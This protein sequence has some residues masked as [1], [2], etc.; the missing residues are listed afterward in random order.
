MLSSFDAEMNQKALRARAK[1]QLRRLRDEANRLTARLVILEAMDGKPRLEVLNA[2]LFDQCRDAAA[3][4]PVVVVREGPVHV[5]GTLGKLKRRRL[6]LTNATA[7]FA[8]DVASNNTN[9]TNSNNNNSNESSAVASAAHSLLSFVHYDRPGARH[10]ASRLEFV[11]GDKVIAVQFASEDESDEWLRVILEQRL[12]LLSLLLDMLPAFRSFILAGVPAKNAAAASSASAPRKSSTQAQVT[13]DL[14]REWEQI[15]E[16][17]PAELRASVPLQ[18]Q[19][20]AIDDPLLLKLGFLEYQRVMML[21]SFASKRIETFATTVETRIKRLEEL[22]DKREALRGEILKLESDL[23]QQKKQVQGVGRDLSSIFDDVLKSVRVVHGALSVQHE[24]L[25]RRAATVFSGIALENEER[26][27][28]EV[29]RDVLEVLNGGLTMDGPLK[30][31]LEELD[32]KETQSAAEVSELEQRR[33]TLQAEVEEEAAKRGELRDVLQSAKSLQESLRSA[34]SLIEKSPKPV[35]LVKWEQIMDTCESGSGSAP[36]DFRKASGRVALRVLQRQDEAVALA[37]RGGEKQ[38][39][40]SSSSSPAADGSDED[41]L[42]P[43]ALVDK[44]LHASHGPL[45]MVV[46]RTFEYYMQ[47]IKLLEQL[48]LTYC[49]TPPTTNRVDAEDAEK[50]LA[51]IRL[52]VLN[53]LRKWVRMHRYHFQSAVMAQMLKNFLSC[54]RL[55]GNEKIVMQIEAEMAAADGESVSSA[56]KFVSVPMLRSG[57]KVATSLEDVKP[58]ELA[59]QL[60]LFDQAVYRKLE[61]REFIKCVFMKKDSQELAPTVKKFTAQF[62]RVAA[63]CATQV[64]SQGAPEARLQTMCFWLETCAHLRRL[65]NYSSLFAIVGGLQSS[66]VKRL[67]GTWAGVPAALISIFESATAL[68]DKNFSGLRAELESAAPPV[69]PY[70]GTYQ[71]DLVYL[72]EGATWKG[73]FVNISKFM[74]ISSVLHNIF[75]YQVASY[76][77]FEELPAIQKILADV[78]VLNED[79]QH[80]RSLAVEPR[81]RGS[82][83]TVVAAP[84]AGRRDTGKISRNDS[85]ASDRPP[86]AQVAPV[87]RIVGDADPNSKNASSSLVASFAAQNALIAPRSADKAASPKPS[88]R[89]SPK[90]SPRDAPPLP[91]INLGESAPEVTSTRTSGALPNAK[92][93]A[94]EP[95]S[96]IAPIPIAVAPAVVTIT[97]TEAAPLSRGSGSSAD[98]SSQLS[99]PA[100]KQWGSASPHTSPRSS[101]TLGVPPPDS[102]KTRVRRRKR[103]IST[104]RRKGTAA[105]PDA[106]PPVVDAAGGEVSAITVVDEE[107]DEEEEDEN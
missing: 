7:D 13:E 96:T 47:P 91:V 15:S 58:E 78:N 49:M 72:D 99:V 5:V 50:K 40:A 77:W 53:F 76:N 51:G 26:R 66:P 67:K 101:I 8:F 104:R 19:H 14:Q 54:A 85:N 95:T 65:H 68:M 88:P 39:D 43:L 59:R 42:T 38:D 35:P 106:A 74:S 32:K 62:N 22:H 70:L 48:V 64:L 46:L 107:E 34:V 1:E 83:A 84:K 55:T 10:D 56:A 33:Q 105:K 86:V 89:T 3:S 12:L 60:C 9:S 98:P 27:A 79:Q 6:V 24:S 28:A 45:E 75:Q 94:T 31:E 17:P 92:P 73:S 71:R 52:R 29:F 57:V 2:K 81:D 102:D 100:P 20:D 21:Q 80:A 37:T 97:S 69:I 18:Y 4:L 30:E 90:T 93:V 11:A 61:V 36:A 103:S 25:R 63:I 44:I 87:I 41:A 16:A 23:A 82:T